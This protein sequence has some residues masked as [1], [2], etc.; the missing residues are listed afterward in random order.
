MRVVE[1]V[2]PVRRRTVLRALGIGLPLVAAAGCTARGLPGLSPPGWGI[3]GDARVSARPT[4]G[5]S[6]RGAAAAL[7]PGLHTLDLGPGPE[8]LVQVPAPSHSNAG[9]PRLVLTLH[10]AGGNAYGGLA[11]LLPLAD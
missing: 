7:A 4:A 2:Q 6:A 1:I 3:F 11:P 9:P 5:G 8:V 10:G